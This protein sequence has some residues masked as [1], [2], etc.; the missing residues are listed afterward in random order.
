[1]QQPSENDH[2]SDRFCAYFFRCFVLM[3]CAS[4]DDTACIAAVVAINFT[5]STQLSTGYAPVCSGSCAP[6][7]AVANNTC[8]NSASF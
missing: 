3:V 2:E 1:M 4:A 7:M 5:C 8:A 6:I